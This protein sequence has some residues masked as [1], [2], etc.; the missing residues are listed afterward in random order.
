MNCLKF[1]EKCITKKCY[2]EIEKALLSHDYHTQKEH[3][4]NG[5][6]VV[7]KMGWH[8]GLAYIN[9][10]ELLTIENDEYQG[11]EVIKRTLSI[12]D[13]NVLIVN[14]EIELDKKGDFLNEFNRKN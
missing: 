3:I 12:F 9:D 6:L 10:C 13:S 4:K 8:V 7:F 14:V 11:D 1:V 5:S 2:K